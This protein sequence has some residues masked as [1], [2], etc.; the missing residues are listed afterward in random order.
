MAFK[1]ISAR[2]RNDKFS[3]ALLNQLIEN[4]Q[5]NEGIQSSDHAFDGRHNVL[6]VARAVALVSW[7]GNNYE[8]K[9]NSEFITNVGRVSTGIVEIQLDQ[10]FFVEPMAV[11]LFPM[12]LGTESVP[13]RHQYKV[14]SIAE[15]QVFTH[16]LSSL[17]GNTWFPADGS[18]AIAV[19]CARYAPDFFASPVPSV[20]FAKRGDTLGF[21]KVNQ[22]I[23]NQATLRQR[24]LLEH[25][26]TGEH[27]ARVIARGF[28]RVSW[29]GSA[30]VLEDAEGV[31]S[32][33]TLGTG[34]CRLNL[35]ADKFDTPMQVFGQAD[36]DRSGG[37]TVLD[38]AM[39]CAPE[40][41]QTASQQDVYLYG[42]DSGDH[43]WDRA[44]VG[45]AVSLHT[46]PE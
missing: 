14:L 9:G 26:D 11:R 6:E 43:T 1:T 36:Y 13:F 10:D 28:A 19:H 39:A 16:R 20:D 33:T 5:W 23:A 34:I 18:F 38:L 46:E 4:Q 22:L 12:D 21:A 3:F 32:V 29:N 42:Y 44:N 2:A 8:L 7:N 31:D 17:G 15:L 35:T 40:S 41:A 37:G 27:N 24:M 30:F 25:T 45:F